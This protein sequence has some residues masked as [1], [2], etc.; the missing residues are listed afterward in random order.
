MDATSGWIDAAWSRFSTQNLGDLCDVCSELLRPL[1]FPAPEKRPLPLRWKPASTNCKLCD[2]IQRAL[3]ASGGLP[4]VEGGKLEDQAKLADAKVETSRETGGIHIALWLK[5]KGK[6]FLNIW[7]YRSYKFYSI[8]VWISDP[9]HRFQ[10]QQDDMTQDSVPK[11]ISQ[12]VLSF[13]QHQVSECDSNHGHDCTSNLGFVNP[14]WP[15]RILEI[16]EPD[17]L[18]ILKDFDVSMER[19]FAALSYCWGASQE[20]KDNPPYKALTTTLGHLRSGVSIA[21]LPRTIREAVMLC[22]RLNIRFIWIDSLC[23]I[24]DSELDSQR[25]ALKMEAVYSLSKL[26]I[27]AAAST[28]CHSGLWPIDA[29]GEDIDLFS[30]QEQ[31]F[32]ITARRHYSSGFHRS[33]AVSQESSDAIDKRGWAYQEDVLSSRYIKFTRDDLQWKCNQRTSCRCGCN[34]TFEYMNQ[35]KPA[36]SSRTHTCIRWEAMVQRFAHR[37]FT[38]ETDKLVAVSSLARKSSPLQPQPAL[39]TLYVAGLWRDD[40]VQQMRWCAYSLSQYHESFISPSFSWA[41]VGITSGKI[42][43]ERLDTTFCDVLQVHCEPEFEENAFGKVK[44]GGYISLSGP[45]L[46]CTARIQFELWHSKPTVTLHES[47]D[48]WPADLRVEDIRMDC[49]LSKYVVEG[50]K[51]SLKRSRGWQIDEGLGTNVELLLLGEMQLG[52]SNPLVGILLAPRLEMQ[53]GGYQRIGHVRLGN[54]ELAKRGTVFGAAHFGK[55]VGEVTI[56]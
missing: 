18:V 11:F 31:A 22:D 13:I 50:G 2:V 56:F 15:A 32:R 4:L 8:M 1:R 34:S 38:V 51:A 26:T 20:L 41:S 52:I 27:I 53:G 17:G 45:L 35:Y 10:E 39:Q 37:Q 33:L 29:Y 47:R 48:A 25:E 24:Q 40:L 16:N 6:L 42:Y 46:P 23:I 30:T 19:Q 5:T 12:R 54:T 55:W 43:D 21:A 3:V 14:G 36:S 28:S 49:P 44:P 9:G 7:N